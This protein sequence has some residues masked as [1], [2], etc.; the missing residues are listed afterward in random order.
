MQEEYWKRGF[1]VK[2]FKYSNLFPKT[3][4]LEFMQ[5]LV[6]YFFFRKTK[7]YF[8]S[9]EFQLFLYSTFLKIHFI[10]FICESAGGDQPEH[11]QRSSLDDLWAL[12]ALLGRH[13]QD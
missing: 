3:I 5:S 6:V 1:Q 9:W 2:K 7:Q 11:V 4:S 8:F 10:N 12:G 13:V